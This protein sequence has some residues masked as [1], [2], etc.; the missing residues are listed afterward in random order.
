MIKKTETNENQSEPTRFQITD[1]KMKL[2]R[3][4]NKKWKKILKYNKSNPYYKKS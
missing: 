1:A 3:I 4:K 2:S